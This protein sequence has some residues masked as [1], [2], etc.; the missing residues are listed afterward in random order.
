MA[1]PNTLLINDEMREEY[2][3]RMAD[4]VA[5]AK[6]TA[7]KR[8]KVWAI[9]LVDK[10]LG[11]SGSGSYKRPTAADESREQQLQQKRRVRAF[12]KQLALD[13]RQGR[14]TGLKQLRK[15]FGNAAEAHAKAHD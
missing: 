13:R 7:D 2:E 1:E 10:Y 12:E 8:N 11:R 3:T 14:D 15:L 6:D 4:S 9:E 5:D